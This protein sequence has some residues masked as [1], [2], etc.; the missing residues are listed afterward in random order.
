MQIDTSKWDKGRHNMFECYFGIASY[1]RADNQRTI[2]YLERIGVDRRYVILSV[3]TAEDKERYEKAGITKQVGKLIYRDGKNVS[4]N[5]NNLLDSVPAGTRLVLLDDDINSIDK[6]KSDKLCPIETAE[7]LY[8]MLKTGYK[9]AAKHKTVGFGLYPVNNAYFMSNGYKERNVVIG[10]LFAIVNTDLRFNPD[11]ATKE[12]FEYCCKA[13]KRYGAFIRLNNYA[14]NAQHYTKGGC[15]EFWN[16]NAEIMRTARRLVGL[17]PDILSLNSKR[18]GE[19]K[20]VKTKK[21]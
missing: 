14:C 4:D 20:M 7:E 5:R 9:L 11:I 12:D 8:A 6:L 15:E 16:D 13:I 19:V 2:K 3:Q 17:Y 21:G 1:K 18:P 10:T